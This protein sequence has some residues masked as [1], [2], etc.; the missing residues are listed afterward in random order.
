MKD[1][2][3]FDEGAYDRLMQEVV[4][5]SNASFAMKDKIPADIKH[6]HTRIDTA[7]HKARRILVDEVAVVSGASSLTDADMDEMYRTH[8][9]LE[10]GKI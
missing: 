4:A 2:L 3:T 1:K 10:E 5:I 8:I 9:N 7:T 6:L